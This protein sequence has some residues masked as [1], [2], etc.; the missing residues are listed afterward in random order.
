[1][2]GGNAKLVKLHNRAL[3]LRVIQQKGRISRKNIAAIIGLTPATITKI[4]EYLLEKELIIEGGSDSNKSA[5]GRKQIYLSINKD[6]YKI[7]SVYIGR[8]TLKGALF[9]LTGNL[10]YKTE[11]N[12]KIMYEKNDAIIGEIIGCIKETLHMCDT[13]LNNVLGIGISA[14]G[15]INAREGIMH[16]LIRE[17]KQNIN[18]QLLAPFDWRGI[19]LK[20]IIQDEFGV[21]VFADNDAN[22]SALAESWF[23]NGIGINNF[24]LY[25]I[26]VGV[27]AGVIIDGMLYNGEDDVVS[28]IGHI[29]VDLN[30]PKCKCGNIGC[31]ELYAS[32]SDIL[33]EYRKRKGKSKISNVYESINYD[34]FIGQMEDFFKSAYAGDADAL[35]LIKKKAE[36]LG[37]GAVS[38]ANMFSPEIIIVST[39]DLGDV[40]LSLIIDELRKCVNKRAFSVIADKVKIVQSRLGK[41]IHL[42]GGVALVLQDFFQMQSVKRF[43]MLAKN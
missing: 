38:L 21:E 24:V 20:K 12:K 9:D 27:G 1:M 29:T 32:F 17:R 35:N 33:E 14:P 13:D 2:K 25:C 43:N 8:Y 42:Y 36:I 41:D 11:Y 26:G 4:T 15:P 40:D 6:K 19:P 28:E 22:V 5:S 16:R 30:G 10:I 31:L 39:N 3:V 7:I 23:G 37:I 34:S 18:S